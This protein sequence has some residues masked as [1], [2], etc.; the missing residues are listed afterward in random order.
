[1][2]A[3]TAAAAGQP[4]G[5]SAA[6]QL[7]TGS[8]L[9]IPPRGYG[10]LIQQQAAA[11]AKALQDAVRRMQQSQKQA[12]QNLQRTTGNLQVRCSDMHD[13]VVAAPSCVLLDVLR[14]G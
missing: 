10:E 9:V 1:V 11:A 13:A 4:T 6:G 8:A 5:L 14:P 3:A 2:S 12:E 7:G